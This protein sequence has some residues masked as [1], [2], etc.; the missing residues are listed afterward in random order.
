ML[1]SLLGSISNNSS[2]LTSHYVPSLSSRVELSIKCNN[3]V[4]MDQ[5]GDLS[6]PFVVVT[7]MN[8]TREEEI[9][10]TEV[11]ANTLNPVFVR[12]IMMLYKFEEIQSL[13]FHVYDADTNFRNDRSEQLDVNKQDYQGSM[14]CSLAEICG[15]AGRTL[16]RP[17][18]HPRSPRMGTIT[19]TAEEQ[20]H[21][22][23]SVRLKFKGEGF[24]SS[25]PFMKLCRT[26]EMMGGAL[27]KTPVF[28]TEVR[29]RTH[30]LH[31]TL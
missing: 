6:D 3:L 21:Q 10:R 27:E 5:G 4:N 15:S 30:Y 9:G 2:T 22:N 8:G 11:I 13:K 29:C 17:L 20:A 23:A 19:V 14:S 16:T 31:G 1:C 24:A 26:K 25:K 7:I 12:K 28:K 18:V